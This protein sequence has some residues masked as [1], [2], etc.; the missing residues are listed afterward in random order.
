M[1]HTQNA[2]RW[3]AASLFG[4]SALA[5]LVIALGLLPSRHAQTQTSGTTDDARY[6]TNYSA[7]YI[8]QVQPGRREDTIRE[9]IPFPKQPA[10]I[11][12]TDKAYTLWL[13]DGN[14]LRSLLEIP[15]DEGRN[16]IQFLDDQ[17][18]FMV[19]SNK[20][21]RVFTLDKTIT[22]PPSPRR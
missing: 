10:F 13:R 17:A 11:V 12:R 9:V 5:A 8:N 20:R 19:I 2:R 21:V 3:T 4:A 14:R 15:T 18:T 22:L 7:F 16:A 6:V 1:P